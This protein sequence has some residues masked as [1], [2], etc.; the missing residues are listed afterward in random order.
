M[1]V[2]GSR[3]AQHHG[4]MLERKPK[5]WDL[6]CTPAQY[7]KFVKKNSSRIIKDEEL[8]HNKRHIILSENKGCPLS[9]HLEFEFA[10]RGNS[11]EDILGL[12]D[13]QSKKQGLFYARPSVLL[14]LK[15]SHKYKKNSPFFKKTM[16]DIHYLRTRGNVEGLSSILKKREQETYTYQ[17]PKLNQKKKDFF[18]TEGVNYKFDHDSIHRAVAR[19][20]EPCYNYFKKDKAE[21]FCSKSKFFDL[22]EEYKLGS[23]VEESIVLALERCLVPF[24]FTTHPNKAF[25]MA[26]EKVCTSISSGWWREYAWE[27]Y[28]QALDLYESEY[29]SY[30]D[31]FMEGLYNGTILKHK[32]V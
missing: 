24:K 22:D 12:R 17:H 29:E 8:S 6:I 14:L 32:E 9:G 25:L 30:V 23:V 28:Y 19:F 4:L 3:A 2:I 7:H 1:L 10:I 27:N 18:N 5:D 11:S 13:H 21:V 15:E 16:D 26:L 20:D 31:K